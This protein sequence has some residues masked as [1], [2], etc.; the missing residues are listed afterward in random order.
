MKIKVSYDSL[1]SLVNLMNLVVSANK[2]TQENLKVVNLFAKDGELNALCTDG[3]LYCL[4]KVKDAIYDL[5]GEENP[6][7]VFNLKEV[8]DILGKFSSL[9][10]TQVSDIYL[11]TQQKGIVMTVIEEPKALKDNDNFAFSDIY[12]NQQSRFKLTR[13]EVSRLILRELEKLV[14]PENNVEVKSK[15]LQKYLEYMFVPLTKPKGVTAMRFQKDYVYSVMNNIYGIAMP[16]I[17]PKDIF[18]D[19]SIN[20]MYLNFFKNF[21]PE[22]DTFK[23]YKDVEV[24]KRANTDE[25]DDETDTHKITLL[26]ESGSRLVR[27]AVNDNTGAIGVDLFKQEISNVIEIDKPYFNDVLKRFEGFD[28]VYLEVVIKE[29]ENVA[30]MT[31]AEFVMKS[32]KNQQRIPVKSATGPSG[33]YKF[34]LR[35]ES[36]GLMT[37]NHLTKDLDGKSEKINDL[38]ICLHRDTVEA[39]SIICNDGAEDWLTR[40]PKAPVKEAPLL[41]F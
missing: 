8:T 17:L 11:Q 6:F 29:D 41:D 34:M 33:E 2:R 23:I 20:S 32:Q 28:T 37:C 27:F 4:E 7:M 40:Y 10:R 22:Y 15:D 5:E 24:I 38:K 16:N 13:T 30:G 1:V 12:K 3:T 19:I 14:M 36:V 35:P 39:V 25:Y 26:I 9:Q 31:T 18:T 21:I